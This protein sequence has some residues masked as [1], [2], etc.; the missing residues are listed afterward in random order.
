MADIFVGGATLYL[1]M[2]IVGMEGIVIVVAAGAVACP[3]S[4][5]LRHM[6]LCEMD[7]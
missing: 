1:Q 2:E 3:F 5:S 7:A 6:L 4:K